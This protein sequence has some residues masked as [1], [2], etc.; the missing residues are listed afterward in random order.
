MYLIKNIGG[1][2]RIIMTDNKL[3]IE[4]LPTVMDATKL[5]P[6]DAEKYDP[7][8][9]GIESS[10]W[11]LFSIL[12]IIATIHDTQEN[13]HQDQGEELLQVLTDKLLT[14][15]ESALVVCEMDYVPSEYKPYFYGIYLEI[16]NSI[17]GKPTEEEMKHLKKQVNIN[18]DEETQKLHYE[19]MDKTLSEV[20][21]YIQILLD[22][23]NIS[24][25]NF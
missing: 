9:H 1:K 16:S 2:N 18:L 15:I 24:N 14:M 6:E 19:M 23:F 4:N 22:K 5:F 8:N 12:T 21:E 13:S 7:I 11:L 20:K 10:K 25:G 3:T 17:Y